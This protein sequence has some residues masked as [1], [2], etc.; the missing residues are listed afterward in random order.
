MII[1]VGVTESKCSKDLGHWLPY[2][3]Y[4]KT[5]II[6]LS[7]YHDLHIFHMYVYKNEFYSY[8]SNYYL[9]N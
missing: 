6:S 3:Q 1:G 2:F 7:T 5:F 9:E 8:I 4:L